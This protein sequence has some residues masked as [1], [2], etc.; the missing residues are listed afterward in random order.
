MTGNRGPPAIMVGQRSPVSDFLN[1]VGIVPHPPVMVPEV[2]GANTRRTRASIAAIAELT[3]RIITGRVET[4]VIVTPHCTLPTGGL[5]AYDEAVLAAHFG[6]FHAPQAMVRAP[7]DGDLLSKIRAVSKDKGQPLAPA[8]GGCIDYGAAVPLYL[9]QRAGWK[10]PIVV[11][12]YNIKANRAPCALDEGT[13]EFGRS[14]RSAVTSLQRSAALLASADLGHWQ[15]RATDNGPG[16]TAP[17]LYTR[18]VV[19]QLQRRSPHRL[20]EMRREHLDAA[21]ECGHSSLLVALG[22][23]K[24][25]GRGCEVLSY[26][27]PFNVGYVVAQLERAAPAGLDATSSA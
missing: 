23:L 16:G 25:T 27:A 11:V 26:E 5:G 6:S 13:M 8:P 9:L 19:T 24:A 4:V 21:A 14:I 3:R 17:R 7:L 1:L 15:G 10:G 18:A 2:G 22:A 12:G 20:A